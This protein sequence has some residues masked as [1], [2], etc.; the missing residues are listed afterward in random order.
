MERCFSTRFPPDGRSERDTPVGVLVGR[1]GGCQ[2][3]SPEKVAG[4]KVF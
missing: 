3:I 2:K 4:S 1:N